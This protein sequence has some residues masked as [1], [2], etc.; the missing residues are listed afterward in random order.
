MIF[1]KSGRDGG[2]NRFSL[3]YEVLDAFSVKGGVMIYQ[4]GED[5]Y[6]KS[7]NENDRFFFEI[8]YSF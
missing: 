6:F 4:S 7:L 1:G 2:I 5:S 3:K 8:R